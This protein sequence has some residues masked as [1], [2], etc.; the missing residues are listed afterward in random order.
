L[1]A[2]RVLSQLPS[3]IRITPNEV[4]ESELATLV[5][6][7]YHTYFFDRPLTPEAQ[8]RFLTDIA[9]FFER[10]ETPLIDASEKRLFQWGFPFE[11]RCAEFEALIPIGDQSWCG[12]YLRT[13]REF[14]REVQPIVS[15]QGRLFDTYD[16]DSAIWRKKEPKKVAP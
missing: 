14:S 15:F 4:F 11:G 10:L 6:R 9:G 8:N 5:S 1:D 7:E 3:G 16:P 13:C 12:E 2:A